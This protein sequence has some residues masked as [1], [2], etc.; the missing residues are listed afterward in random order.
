MNVATSQAEKLA[1]SWAV[2]ETII[3]KVIT[4]KNNKMK[5]VTIM[6]EEIT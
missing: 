3:N 5:H 6:E 2:V 1:E 4:N